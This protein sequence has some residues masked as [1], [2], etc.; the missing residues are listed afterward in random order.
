MIVGM[1]TDIIELARIEATLSRLGD[2]FA[3]RILDD[4]EFLIYQHSKLSLNYLAKRFAIKEAAAK[5]LGTGIGRG[6]SWRHMHTSNSDL[7]APC[8]RFSDG[9]QTQF[10]ALGASHCHL[11]VSDE[12][13]YAV[14]HVILESG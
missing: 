4:N 2:A 10:L 1:G 8:L 9:A 13:H 6:V 7:G 3:R 12:Q 5:A 11:S 14:A